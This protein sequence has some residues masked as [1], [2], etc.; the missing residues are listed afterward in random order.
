M[1]MRLQ[2]LGLGAALLFLLTATAGTA[3]AADQPQWGEK[4]SRNMVSAETGLPDSF[5]PETGKNIKWKAQLGSQT[6]ATPTVAGGC[7]LIGT[8]NGNPRD[9]RL[10]G[11][12]GVLL[13]LDEKTGAMKWQ[14]V[15]PKIRDDK[16][17]DWLQNGN[18]AATKM[19]TDQYMD[20]PEIGPSSPATIDG[21]RVYTLTNRSEVVCLDLAGMANGNDGPYQDEGKHMVARAAAP[22]EPGKTDADIIW[23][24][25]LPGQAGVWP[26]DSTHAS[27]LVRGD[28]LYINTCNGVDSTH[29]KIRAPGAPGLIILDKKTGKLIA[30]DN[31][32]VGEQVIHSNW[33]SPALG[34]VGGQTMLIWASGDGVVRAFK[35]LASGATASAGLERL[36]LFD[37]DPAN[38]RPANHAYMKNRN[39]GP[40]DVN[41]MPVLVGN[42][43]YVAGGGDFQWG[44]HAGWVKCIDA[45][46]KGDVTKSAELWA[47][48]TMKDTC[49]TPAVA[50]G[51]VF[52]TDCGGTLHC[53]DAET[54]KGVWTHQLKGEVWGSALVA[55]GKVYVGSKG[56]EFCILAAAREKKVLATVSLPSDSS[57]TPAAANG[58]L[59]VTTANALYAVQAGGK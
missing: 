1:M 38:L 36:W 45:T 54:G 31:E 20:W 11:D 18:G 8:N 23:L 58:V 59:Y 41:G 19:T 33:S 52:V 55:D 21:D 5:D 32:A 47:Y 24:F 42:R 14:L 56:K 50:G 22:L 28:H 35:A 51:M 13:C 4:N 15:C 12:R 10:K 7:V 26:H 40:S 16:E 46:Q 6:Y 44:K 3:V 2:L 57:S 29:K 37:P 34:D 9:P 43:V 30:R 25:D 48:T 39:A 27:I 53:I 17:R 49:A